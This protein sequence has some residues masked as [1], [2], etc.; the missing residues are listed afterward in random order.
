M[1][2]NLLA[3]P[4]TLF[5]INIPVLQHVQ[6]VPYAR[7]C[8]MKYPRGYELQQPF[9]LHKFSEFLLKREK[10]TILCIIRQYLC[11][12]LMTGGRAGLSR[13]QFPCVMIDLCPGPCTPGGLEA[14]G[15][16][17][18]HPCPG[19]TQGFVGPVLHPITAWPCSD[20]V[21]HTPD[22]LDCL[23]TASLHGL[24]LWKAKLAPW[25]MT[26]W[27]ASLSSEGM[28][29]KGGCPFKL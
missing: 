26:T 21:N 5:S 17:L 13:S 4:H 8:C 25:W 22:E 6:G 16:P 11:K 2:Q 14:P 15:M 1:L 20:C 3:F 12:L 7:H 19:F 28:I 10:C 24:C 27:V 9:S 29:H 23:G 18:C